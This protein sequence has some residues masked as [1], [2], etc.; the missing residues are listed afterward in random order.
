MKK[1]TGVNFI[2]YKR[3][4]KTLK[5]NKSH[6]KKLTGNDKIRLNNLLKKT[7]FYKDI[8]KY[9]LKNNCK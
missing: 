8:I 7:D 9:M 2:T 3:D 5:A 4:I 6:W 1:K